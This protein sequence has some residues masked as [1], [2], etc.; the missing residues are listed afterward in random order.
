MFDLG[1]RCGGYGARWL[2]QWRSSTIGKVDPSEA[3]VRGF[4]IVVNAWNRY[5][6]CHNGE[7]PEE[8]YD[9]ILQNSEG[10]TVGELRWYGFPVYVPPR[11]NTDLRQNAKW[12]VFVRERD[13][14][15]ESWE[16]YADGT[17]ARV[18]NR[19]SRGGGGPPPEAIAPGAMPSEK[20]RSAG[21]PVWE[22][23]SLADRA[24]WLEKNKDV[25]VWDASRQMYVVSQ[26]LRGIKTKRPADSRPASNTGDGPARGAT[27]SRWT[28]GY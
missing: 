14:L 1:K 23:T 20:L 11:I 8:P 13:D 18:A 4:A 10:V 12:L 7:L 19:T 2:G 27:S 9:A 22:W 16:C 6:A 3:D 24:R 5:I 15:G 25:L 21:F 17:W 26:R 28:D